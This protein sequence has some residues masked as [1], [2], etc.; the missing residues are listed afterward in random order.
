M[1]DNGNA[2]FLHAAGFDDDGCLL[3]LIQYCTVT[4]EQARSQMLAG[5]LVP[6][7][8]FSH[9]RLPFWSSLTPVLLHELH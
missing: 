7:G 8:I 9:L 1:L 4:L 6:T 3:V 5:S 2:L